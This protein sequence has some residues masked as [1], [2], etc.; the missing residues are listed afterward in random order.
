MRLHTI[1]KTWYGNSY[2]TH[3]FVQFQGELSREMWH[4]CCL[5]VSHRACCSSLKLCAHSSPP[6]QHW[7]CYNAESSRLNIQQAPHKSPAWLYGNLSTWLGEPQASGRKCSARKPLHIH[8]VC[9][10]GDL[11]A[12]NCSSSTHRLKPGQSLCLHCQPTLSPVTC[13]LLDPALAFNMMA[14]SSVV[15][16]LLTHWRCSNLGDTR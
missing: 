15:A 13:C 5:C 4:I 3:T 14:D 8:Q 10:M 1:T 11:P 12:P 6:C 2:L 9:R 16:C 7:H